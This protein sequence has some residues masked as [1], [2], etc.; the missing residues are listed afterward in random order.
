L[1]AGIDDDA[2]DGARQYPVYG[3]A[4]RQSVPRRAEQVPGVVCRD[5]AA[6]RDGRAP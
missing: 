5:A 3:Q 1:R 4:G 2:K 6:E